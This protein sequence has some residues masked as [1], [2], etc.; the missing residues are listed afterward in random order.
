MPTRNTTISQRQERR[1]IDYRREARPVPTPIPA[2]QKL[3]APGAG[4]YRAQVQ[5]IA[6]DEVDG[7]ISV[8]LKDAAGT[9]VGSD[10]DV[11]VLW[12]KATLDL[13]EY[14]PDI[15]VDTYV[16]VTKDQNGE[17]HLAMTVEEFDE[18]A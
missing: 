13:T 7:T 1:R 18:C 2:R 10:F 9:D 8:V 3:L 14:K 15:E 4:I 5:S 12:S 17:W 11:Y 16:P 6:N